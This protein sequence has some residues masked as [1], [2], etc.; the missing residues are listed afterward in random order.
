M[1]IDFP[2]PLP[3][4]QGEL[5]QLQQN[6]EAT[7]IS[8]KEYRIHWLGAK[9]LSDSQMQHAVDN[10]DTLSDAVRGL[11]AALYAAGYPASR[12]SYALSGQDLYVLATIGKVSTVAMDPPIAPYFRGLAGADPLTDDALERR[13]VL[14]SIHADRAGIAATPSFAPG[15]SVVPV[16]D[17]SSA[18]PSAP[19]SSD[20]TMSLMPNPGEAPDQ[21]RFRLEFGNPGNRF[22]GRYFA[23]LDVRAGTGDG[24]EFRSFS[25]FG[26]HG[27][28]TSSDDDSRSGTY[29]EQNLG[30]NRVT[31]FGIFGIGGRYAYYGLQESPIVPMPVTGLIRSGEAYWLFPLFA[32][33]NS[34]TTIT[35]KVDRI[36]KTTDLRDEDLKVQQELYNSVELGAS[37]ISSFN[38][39][40][41]HWDFEGGLSGRKGLGA[42]SAPLTTADQ[43][44][45][46]L[47]PGLR[48]KYFLTDRY[49]LGLEASGQYSDATVPEQQ[50]WVLGGLGNL[51]AYLPGVAVGDKGY[52]VRA[53]GEAGAFPVYH[54]SEIRPRVFVEYGA[55]RYNDLGGGLPRTADAGVELGLK[56]LPWLSGSVAYARSFVYKDIPES[57]RDATDAR[58]YFRLQGEYG[59]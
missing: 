54:G 5:Q 23:D 19:L 14:A 40:G 34:R 15:V 29:G 47:R 43:S 2:P 59:S 1:A 50:Q 10:K 41:H 4:Q 37:Y 8:F 21:D 3:P 11:A 42:E 27:L 55:T 28:N 51:S 56:F 53:Q 9:P 12:L 17:G 36:G 6:P 46:L 33:I 39:L 35:A 18:T 58:V 45:F 31:P 25:R 13:R 16:S 30:W 38:F 20:Y 26:I 44:Y 22:V 52:L 49:S 48:L 32:N 57:V 24:D 7:A